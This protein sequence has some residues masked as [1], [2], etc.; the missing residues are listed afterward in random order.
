ML[1]GDVVAT[2]SVVDA[3]VG[4]MYHSMAPSVIVAITSA[5][6]NSNTQAWQ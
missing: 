3:T 2:V 5:T 1:V 4:M 6:K